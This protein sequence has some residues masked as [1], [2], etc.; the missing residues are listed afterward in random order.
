MNAICLL[1][2]HSLVSD[3][4]ATAF[5]LKLGYAKLELHGVNGSAYIKFAFNLCLISIAFS[6][7]PL[8]AR[9]S[10]NLTLISPLI[11][12]PLLLAFFLFYPKFVAKKAE[13]KE[14]IDSVYCFDLFAMVVSL[15]GSFEIASLYACRT[16]KSGV[17]KRFRRALFVIR[18]GT[19]P[20]KAIMI[21]FGTKKRYTDWLRSVVYGSESD[22]A[23]ILM[24]W[25]TEMVRGVSKVEDAMAFFTVITT[26]LPVVTSITVLI[27]GWG[28]S[29][30]IFV[31]VVLQPSAFMVVYLW[32][33]D[34]VL[35]V[36]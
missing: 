14:F 1:S 4:L 16:S 27:W 3:K 18:C 15:T 17:S 22:A 2:R 21:A 34:L 26:L 13:L 10:H 5:S 36:A 28:N 6:F 35:P 33:K 25:N 29:L 32:F 19:D 20:K 9:V 31:I 12:P 23:S 7:L 24:W 30:L 8:I 11:V